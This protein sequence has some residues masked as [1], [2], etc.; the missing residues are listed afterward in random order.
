MTTTTFNMGGDERGVKIT[1]EQNG[2]IAT[3]TITQN[4][5]QPQLDYAAWHHLK[6][7]LQQDFVNDGLATLHELIG[8]THADAAL[9][10]LS[11]PDDTQTLPYKLT[12]TAK[13]PEMADALIARVQAEAS[14][15]STPQKVVDASNNPHSPSQLQP[16]AFAAGSTTQLNP[17]GLS[18]TAE[19]IRALKKSNERPSNE[20]LAELETL[21]TAIVGAQ[22]HYGV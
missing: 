22:Q 6:E 19:L 10:A 13:T 16:L 14:R 15:L 9:Q 7:Q 4:R 2:N 1:A 11:T 18:R 12:Y 20:L 21:R 8:S 3:I 5:A 17:E